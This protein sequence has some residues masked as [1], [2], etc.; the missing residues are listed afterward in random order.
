MIYKTTRELTV[1][2]LE[3][4]TPTIRKIED[5]PSVLVSARNYFGSSVEWAMSAEDAKEIKIGT[6]LLFQLPE[7]KNGD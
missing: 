5:K 3:V 4:Y 1:F 7:I 6:K 2:R